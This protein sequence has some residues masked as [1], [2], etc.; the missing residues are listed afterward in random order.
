MSRVLF[1][2]S[3]ELQCV[4]ADNMF[5]HFTKYESFFVGLLIVVN[6]KGPMEIQQKLTVAGI[7]LLSH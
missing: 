3:C 2:Y 4:Y 1:V 7:F 5:V 6:Y